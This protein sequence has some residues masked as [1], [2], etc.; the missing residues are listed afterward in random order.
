MIICCY[1]LKGY[2]YARSNNP[3]RE[4]VEECLAAVEGAKHC[5]TFSSGLG[6]TTVILNLLNSGDHVVA[7]DDLYGGTYRLFSKVLSRMGVSFSFVDARDPGKVL[8]AI[9]PNTKVKS[10]V[11]QF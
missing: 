2:E 7:G 11:V 8:E 6:A 5:V 10:H 9:Q 3:T 4:A 1:L